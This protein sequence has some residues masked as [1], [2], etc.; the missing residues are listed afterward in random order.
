MSWCDIPAYHDWMISDADLPVKQNIETTWTMALSTLEW[1][2]DRERTVQNL[3][4]V[5]LRGLSITWGS[6]FRLII[7]PLDM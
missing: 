6:L 4:L 1:S 7:T 5:T 3:S 2:K